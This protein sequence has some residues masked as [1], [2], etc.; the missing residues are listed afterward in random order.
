MV[1]DET[2]VVSSVDDLVDFYRETNNGNDLYIGI[3]WERSGV[4]R[5]TLKPVKYEGDQGYLAVLKKLAAE[6]GW[7]I[8]DGH[9]NYIGE[10]RRGEAKVTLE[11]DGRLEL[12]GS[13][14]KNLHDLAREFR[15][16][17]N[18][19]KEVSDFFNIAWLPIGWQPFH[20]DKEIEFA[21]KDRYEI[22][23]SFGTNEWMESEMKRNNG[24]T[25]NYSY[26]DEK[27]AIKKAQI[28]FRIAPI[29][30]AVFAS[31]PFNEG[32]LSDCLDMRRYCKSHINPERHSVPKNILDKNFSLKDWISFYTKM[33]VYLIKRKDKKDLKPENLTFDKWIKEG[34]DGIFPTIYDFD[35]HIKTTWSDI[36]LRPNYLEYRVSDSVPM[37]YAMGVPALVKGLVFDSK[38]WGAVEDLTRDWTYEDILKANKEA[39][40]H[41]LLTEIKGKNLLWYAKSFIHIANDALHKFART[42]ASSDATDESVFL[43]SIKDQ[44]YIKEKSIASE[45]VELWKNDWD[46]NPKRLIEWCEKE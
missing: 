35:Q 23:N 34:Y 18:E 5:D 30:G 43:A 41:G 15:I 26:S 24:L 40:T 32:K 27:N 25:V 4:Y 46:E 21:G 42:T 22:L 7:E 1:L 36:R 8:A 3:E 44:I 28:G 13:P 10:L 37:R 12:A 17:A 39:L 2:S 20:S 33:T 31:A 6:A 11:A 29:V 38:S 16:H 19:V 9:R 45:M 14:K